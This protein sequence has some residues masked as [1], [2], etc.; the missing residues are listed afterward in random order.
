MPDGRT[1]QDPFAPLRGIVS[2]MLTM[3]LLM[4][5]IY[6]TVMAIH[7]VF[8]E[9]PAPV[10]MATIGEQEACTVVDHEAV[11][12]TTGVSQRGVRPDVA[13]AAADTVRVCLEDPTPWQKAA[14]AVE[15]VGHLVFALGA[16]LLVKRV[17]RAAQNGLF[18]ELTAKRTK[19]LGWFML[20]MSLGWPFLAAGGRAVIV[21][22]AAKEARLGEVWFAPGVQLSLVVVSLGVLS[23]SR[24]VRRAVPMQDELDVTV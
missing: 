7:L 14:A 10:T 8:G 5:G 2:V 1:N 23:V 17:M 21:E 12:W 3:L 13:R 4:L 19:H 20:A 15:P 22:A 11:P 9:G 24:V 6:V 16:L 18:T